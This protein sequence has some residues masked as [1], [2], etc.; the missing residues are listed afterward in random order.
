MTA[1]KNWLSRR[2]LE[3]LPALLHLSA[4]ALAPAAIRANGGA[5]A[6]AAG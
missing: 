1:L 6:P 2:L 3:Q 5:N 4:A